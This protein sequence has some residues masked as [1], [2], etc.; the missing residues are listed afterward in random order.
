MRKR[1]IITLV[2]AIVAAAVI[3][4]YSGGYRVIGKIETV[5]KDGYVTVLCAEMLHDTEYT[6]L[7]GEELVIGRINSIE[8]LQDK[9]GFYRYIARFTTA[10]KV[11]EG[12]IRSG[13]GVILKSPDREVDS[14]FIPNRFSEKNIYRDKIITSVDGREMVLIQEGDFNMGSSYGDMDEFPEHTEYLPDYYID[15]YE[16]SNNDYRAYADAEGIS[17]PAYW[18]EFLTPSGTFTDVY[19]S[20][21]PVIVSYTEAESY[22]KWAGKRLPDEREWE[23]AARFPLETDKTGQV[24]VYTWGYEFKDGISNTGEFWTD[25]KTGENLKFTIKQRFG[26][27][28]LTKGLIPVNIY[29]P[30]SVSYYGC[31]A[32]DGNA[33]EWTSSWYRAY[34]GNTVKDKKYGTQYKVIRGGSWFTSRKEA[35]VTDRKIGGIPDLKSD[36]IA[37]IRCAKAVSDNDRK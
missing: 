7:N 19:F 8:R 17:Y 31:A 30:V 25:D 18:K 21:L 5:R 1:G 6:V 24:S 20:Q 15:K 3:G 22:S 9:D 37:G 34:K 28:V 14:D 36:R 29:E 26:L 2:S 10:D 32:M 23:K 35:R 16:V 27:Q 33:Q 4:V 12:L 11:P 13:A